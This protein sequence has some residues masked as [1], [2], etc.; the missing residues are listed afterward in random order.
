MAPP[1]R[2]QFR[3]FVEI[4]VRWGDMDAFGHVNN[5]VFVQYIES[6]RVDYFTTV[7]DSFGHTDEG[8]ILGEVTCRFLT[9]VEYPADLHIGTRVV[10][11]SNRTL[12]LQTGIFVAD[13]RDPAAVGLA[14]V[15]W[16]DYRARQS[17]TLPARLLVAVVNFEPEPPERG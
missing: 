10:G 7:L 1:S 2:E 13:N 16:F 17:A 14:T 12:R 5:A 4:P 15:V 9:Q 8:P 11:L 6:G 3:H